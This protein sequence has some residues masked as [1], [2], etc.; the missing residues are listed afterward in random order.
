[1]KWILASVLACLSAVAFAACSAAPAATDSAEPTASGQVVM[2]QEEFDAAVNSAVASALA[3]QTAAASETPAPEVVA[4]VE[5]LLIMDQNKV[6]VYYTGYDPEGSYSGPTVNLRIENGA[7]IS[8]IVQQRDMAVNNIMTSANISDTVSAGK[9]SN[10]QIRI[11][12]K[13][14]AANGITD[15][16]TVE[17]TLHVFQS[18][19]WSN[20]F[21]SPPIIINVGA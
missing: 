5:D 2:S 10:A 6:R 20:S 4:P 3:Q 8:Y 7:D 14:L 11:D 18:D 19:D 16:Q 21:D 12:A 17:F 9:T 13:D 15:V 1:M